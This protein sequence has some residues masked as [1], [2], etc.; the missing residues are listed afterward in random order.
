VGEV[1]A[2]AAAF[3]NL[4]AAQAAPLAGAEA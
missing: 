1:F 3:L 4:A 2:P